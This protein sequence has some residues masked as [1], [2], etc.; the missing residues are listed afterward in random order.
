MWRIVEGERIGG[1]TQGGSVGL[2]GGGIIVGTAF[3]P[4]VFKLRVGRSGSEGL[5]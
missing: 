5:T 1:D 3:S 2:R 4:H